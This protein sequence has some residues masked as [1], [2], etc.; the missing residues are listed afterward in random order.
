[1][2]CKNEKTNIEIDVLSLESSSNNN[3]MAYHI[4]DLNAGVRQNQNVMKSFYKVV[5]RTGKVVLFCTRSTSTSKSNA[6]SKY[7]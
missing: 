7:I 1:M 3:K 5:Q 4:K 6:K 2:P